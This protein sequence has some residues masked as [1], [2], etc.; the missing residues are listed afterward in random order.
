MDSFALIIYA[1]IHLEH[2]QQMKNFPLKLPFYSNFV[3]WFCT[4][5]FAAC[6]TCCSTGQQAKDSQQPTEKNPAAEGFD[7]AGSDPQAIA[8]ADEVME[9]MGG[10]QAWDSTRHIY[11]NFFGART[12]LWDKWT[13]NVRIE[14][15]RSGNLTLVNIYSGEGRAMKNGEEVMHPDSLAKVLEQGK[16]AWINDS[17]WLVMPFKLKDSGVTLKYAGVDTVAEA[18][19]ADVLQLTFREVGVTPQNKYLVYVSHADRLVCQWAYFREASDENPSFRLLW[20]NYQQHG[21]IKLS[22]DREA[23]QLTDIAVFDE[24]PETLYQSLG[25]VDLSAYPRAGKP[26]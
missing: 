1:L 17:Y 20:R 3:Y 2:F 15:L 12:L 26:I 24:L 6:V 14:D 10:R 13:G 21:R 18:G 8:I 4:L 19:A 11:W 23:R 7:L 25:P 9:A 5:A 16:S 22:G